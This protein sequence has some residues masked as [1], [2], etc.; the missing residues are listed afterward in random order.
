[1]IHLCALARRVNYAQE[2]DSGAS[3]L[4]SQTVA[5]G[6]PPT[7]PIAESVKVRRLL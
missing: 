6:A 1:M 7:T 5:G 3:L 4:S 2:L